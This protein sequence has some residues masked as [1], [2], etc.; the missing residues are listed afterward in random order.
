MS[1]KLSRTRGLETLIGICIKIVDKN[2]S[3]FM[4]DTKKLQAFA[5]QRFT[6]WYMFSVDFASI[7]IQHEPSLF[8]APAALYVSEMQ[9]EVTRH[10]YIRSH[11][12]HF[13]PVGKSLACCVI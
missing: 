9:P 1:V 11:L 8:A 3:D 5:T 13:V 4:R 2:I 6:Q 12:G 7:K 10:I